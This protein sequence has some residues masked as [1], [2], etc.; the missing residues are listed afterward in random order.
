[1]TASSDTPGLIPNPTITYTSPNAT[2][3]LKYTPVANQ[4]GTA[5]IT[6]TVKDDGGTA[7]GGD[8]TK[9]RTFTITVNSVNDEPPWTRSATR[10]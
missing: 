4:H 7:N 9:T 8:D 5:T 1:M 3:T 6:V 2:G 10:R